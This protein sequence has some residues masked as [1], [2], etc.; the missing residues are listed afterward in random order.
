MIVLYLIFFKKP[1]IS[2]AIKSL[3]KT[4]CLWGRV[5]KLDIIGV[6]SKLILRH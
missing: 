5:G 6:D 3:A 4:K 2:I 1:L